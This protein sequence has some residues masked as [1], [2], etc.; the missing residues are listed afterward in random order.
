MQNTD[1]SHSMTAAK[2]MTPIDKMIVW[3]MA[4]IDGYCATKEA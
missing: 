1:A 4:G 2:L 3:K